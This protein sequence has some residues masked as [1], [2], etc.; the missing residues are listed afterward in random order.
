MEIVRNDT[1]YAMRALVYLAQHHKQGPITAKVLAKTQDIPDSFAYKILRRLSKA[2]LTK[3][4]MGPQGGF[5]LAQDP[6]QITLLKVVEATQ[7]PVVVRKC[8]LGVDVC[9]RRS[10]CPISVKLEQLQDNLVGFLENIT[11]AEVLEARYP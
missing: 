9:P 3:G 5:A 4:H 2:G 6:R 1:D 10:S 8:L 11:L 7:G